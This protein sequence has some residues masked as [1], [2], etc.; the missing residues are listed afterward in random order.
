MVQGFTQRE[1][2]LERA[3]FLETA[4]GGLK[5][6]LKAHPIQEDDPLLLD[7]IAKVLEARKRLNLPVATCEACGI[8]WDGRSPPPPAK[9]RACDHEEMKA[10][11]VELKTTGLAR[12]PDESRDEFFHR[13]G[14]ALYGW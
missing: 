13:V 3:H 9:T 5:A 11:W 1:S 4:L 2:E 12:G 8:E 6:A 14:V 7:S 10:M